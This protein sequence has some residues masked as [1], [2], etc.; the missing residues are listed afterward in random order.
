M[1]VNAKK[2]RIG[3][4]SMKVYEGFLDRVVLHTTCCQGHEKHDLIKTETFFGEM[5]IYDANK[6]HRL[7]DHGATCTADDAVSRTITNGVYEPHETLTFTN[8]LAKNPQGLVLD[9]G[10]HVGWYSMIAALAGHK[11]IAWDSNSERL[12]ILKKNAELNGV[13]DLIKT[14]HCWVG[15][16]SETV[17]I[18]EAVVVLKCDLEGAEEHVIR[19]C[20][21]LLEQNKIKYLLLEIS[22]CINDSYPTLLK[23]LYSIGYKAVDV[24]RVRN[25]V[26]KVEDIDDYIKSIKQENLL[27]FKDE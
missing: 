13:S 5:F 25:G 4:R 23:Y 24:C 22:P 21:P 1:F 2:E 8:I 19:I 16:D 9:F 12:D 15:K 10:S 14:E 18:S 6:Y 11:V 7:P 3:G 26:I 17:P 20:K 27:F